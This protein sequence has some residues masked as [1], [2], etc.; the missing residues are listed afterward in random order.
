MRKSVLEMFPNIHRQSYSVPPIRLSATK[1]S[2]LAHLSSNRHDVREQREKQPA[3]LLGDQTEDTITRFVAQ[4]AEA[5]DEPMFLLSSYSFDDYLFYMEKK[6]GKSK[7]GRSER[8]AMIPADPELLGSS[9]SSKVRRKALFQGPPGKSDEVADP[10][11]SE[12]NGE[13]GPVSSEGRSTD[14]SGHQLD[15]EADQWVTER[16]GCGAEPR[17]S[18]SWS[19]L[20]CKYMFPSPRDLDPKSRRG[21][22]DNLII[23]PRHGFIVIEAKTMLGR[24]MSVPQGERFGENQPER[25]PEIPNKHVNNLCEDDRGPQTAALGCETETQVD[26]Q[27]FPKLKRE[28][29]TPSDPSSLEENSAESAHSPLSKDDVD[30]E[31]WKTIRKSL[32]QLRKAETVLRHVTSDLAEVAITKVLGLP[33][34]PAVAL[35]RLLEDPA[36]S[37][38]CTQTPSTGLR[39]PSFNHC[40]I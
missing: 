13:K 20:P 35:R 7:D 24:K 40:R 4:V 31:F 28:T 37:E 11:G 3:A 14:G 29:E 21:D 36:L 26:S 32:D 38:V 34:T 33:N 9:S 22:F 23:S 2:Q 12:R 19:S 16:E 8:P 6:D 15:L 27:A 30:E 17:L 1:Y 25:V 39:H 10:G 5:V 18:A